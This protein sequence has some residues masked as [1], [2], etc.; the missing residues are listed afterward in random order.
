M[1][2]YLLFAVTAI[3][4]ANVSAQE[5]KDITPSKYDFSQ[6]EV[7]PYKPDLVVH[8]ANIQNDAPA[9]GG[10][11]AQKKQEAIFDMENLQP[12]CIL[13]GGRYTSKEE[14]MASYASNLIAG[15]G[16]VD[17]G[18]EVGKVLAI[19]GK[20]SKINEKLK[21]LFPEWTGEIPLAAGQWGWGNINWT[22]DP[23]DPPVVETTGTFDI[24]CRLV[25]N[26]YANEPSE[27]QNIFG[28]AFG[29]TVGAN[30]I[31][32]PG[33]NSNN[34]GIKSGEFIQLYEDG[35][36][37]LD[38]DDNYVWDPNKW[39][40]YE[41]DTALNPSDPQTLATRI[42][43]SLDGSEAG[44]DQA[45][46]F[47]KEIKFFKNT[48]DPVTEASEALAR[49]SFQKLTPDPVA[50]VNTINAE[51]NAEKKIYTVSGIEVGSKNQ[52]G[53]YV[54]KVGNKTRKV[55]VR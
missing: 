7:G 19:S 31:V 34:A 25:L 13:S 49:T 43:I 45:T 26:V 20:D 42:R 29:C 2:K 21:E 4:A 8:G 48:E 15:M 9:D 14:P 37:V 18:G 22:T 5:L 30:N 40:V 16:I 55:V 33:S 39:M 1:K 32:P 51:N 50:S 38:D 27:S 41:F 11:N 23:N 44:M 6:M 52:K 10:D 53:V 28:P 35:D 54:E 17:L 46:V 12:L 36:P 47:I 3:F 24:R